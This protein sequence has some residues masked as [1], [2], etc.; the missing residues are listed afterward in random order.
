MF[1]WP[2]RELL[3]GSTGNAPRTGSRKAP[4][5]FLKATLREDSSLDQILSRSHGGTEMHENEIGT[6]IVQSAV[7]L[8]QDL[9]PGLLESVYEVTL[10]AQ[11]ERH[12]LKVNRQFPVAIE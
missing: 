10:A 7:Q 12:G 4:S 3:M 1:G 8:H 2:I 5:V 9:G 11:L 6:L